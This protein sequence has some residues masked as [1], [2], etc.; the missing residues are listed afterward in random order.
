VNAGTDRRRMRRGVAALAVVALLIAPLAALALTPKS[1]GW[2]GQSSQGK[3]VS[4]SVGRGKVR[5]VHFSWRANCS[6]GSAAGTTT[7]SKPLSINGNNHFSYSS[8]GTTFNGKFTSKRQ[9]KGTL[10]YKFTD[11]GT[12][13]TCS[14]GRVGWH[15]HH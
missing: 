10:S 9:A 11:Y 15:A 3:S 12:G 6:F 14:S 1:G 13:G 5:N 4:F 8:S 7:L 2:S